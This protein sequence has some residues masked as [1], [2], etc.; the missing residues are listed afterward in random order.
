MRKTI[1][2]AAIVTVL[3]ASAASADSTDVRLDKMKLSGTVEGQMR[4]MRHASL[5]RM[6][7]GAGSDLY[8]RMVEIGIETGFSSWVAAIAV[9][10]SEWI[11][12]Y[13]NAGDE[14]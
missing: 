13:M 3:M 8:I 6:D 4:Y 11:G 12:D 7:S 9:L 2:F 14:R 1:L 5:S 10:N